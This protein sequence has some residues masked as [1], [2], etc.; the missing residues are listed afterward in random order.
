MKES[1]STDNL[2]QNIKSMLYGIAWLVLGGFL[3]LG[4]LLLILTDHSAAALPFLF[5]GVLLCIAGILYVRYG[6]RHPHEDPE[7]SNE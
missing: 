3:C 2:L 5:P 1:G 6:F 4:G 7:S